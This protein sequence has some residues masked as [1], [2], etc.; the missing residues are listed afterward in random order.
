[1]RHP[2]RIIAG[3]GLAAGLAAACDP[4]A[5]AAD[6]ATFRSKLDPRLMAATQS[7]E[8][9]TVWVG[10]RDKG[11]AGPGDVARALALARAAL[12]PRAL[13]RRQRA[14]V[15]PLVDER[16]IPIHAPYVA[17][18]AARGLAPFGASRWFNQVA[19]RVPGTR[20]LEIG[21]L[22]FVAGLREV[23]H[24]ARSAD[25]PGTGAAAW[26]ARVAGERAG[27]AEAIDYGRTL[28]QLE[29]IALPALH[30]SGYAG[31][32]VLVCILDEGFNA[33]DTHEAL[34]GVAIGPGFQRD[35]VDGDW[36][37]TDPANFSD[38]NHGTQVMGLL[39]ADRRGAYVGAAYGASYALG[40]TEVH[41]SE[42]QVEMVYWG[43]GAEWADSLGADIISSSVGYTE[44]DAPDPSYVYA[45]LNG[46][47]TIV[48]RA[49]E[50]AA[51]KGILV[52]NSVGNAGQMPWK[53]LVA[54]AD[55]NG[56]SVIAVGAVD[57]FGTPGGFSSYGP[58]AD[59]RVKPDLAARGVGNPL[60]DPVAGPAG[61]TSL[62]GTSF[63]AP[64]V[65]GLAACVMQ[66]RPTWR[67]VDVIRAL[68]ETASRASW[69][70]DRV[71]YGIPSGVRA[72]CWQPASSMP[73]SVP[74]A[75]VLGP[76]P[77]RADGPATAVRFAAGGFLPGSNPARIEVL[78]LAGRA[79]RELWSGMLARGQCITVG[80]DGRDGASRAAEPGIYFI[81]LKVGGQVTAARVAALR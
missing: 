17:A 74:A 64:L 45:N 61:Y 33:H 39:A 5:V 48:T 24:A 79:V 40:R 81:S 6:S 76:N 62:D 59:N 63:S 15:Q 36:D 9:V 34:S 14:G 3:L 50:I 72:L 46:S 21:A 49:A 4:A 16:D 56:D 68:R 25:P 20:L 26:P 7:P 28:A 12:T 73:S 41:A 77:H 55:A 75:E 43:M 70:D 22:P 51:S 67:P 65:A 10:F 42:H 54:P 19:V 11:E 66:A 35:F 60:I 57:D 2:A 53:Y 58:S 1:M 69:P 47:T 71:G 38:Y 23:E 13:A 30:D 80:W 27:R 37:V 32:G 18:L 78:D 44:F 31:T 8:P 29:Q 52:V